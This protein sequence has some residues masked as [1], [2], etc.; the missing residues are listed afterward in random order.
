MLNPEQKQEVIQSFTNYGWCDRYTTN[1]PYPIRQVYASFKNDPE[2]I[3]TY[4]NPKQSYAWIDFEEVESHNIQKKQYQSA[5][6]MITHRLITGLWGLPMCRDPTELVIYGGFARSA[7]IAYTTCKSAIYKFMLCWRKMTG[8]RIQPD[9]AKL[10][11]GP[12]IASWFDSMVYF[13]DKINDI[14]VLV[15]YDEKPTEDQFRMTVNTI[16]EEISGMFR[17]KQNTGYSYNY[18][19]NDGGFDRN[20]CREGETSHKTG[21]YFNYAVY[22]DQD[23]HKGKHFKHTGKQIKLDITALIDSDQSDVD[24]NNV[25]L[26]FDRTKGRFRFRQ[27]K[28]LMYWGPELTMEQIVKSLMTRTFRPVVLKFKAFDSI[29]VFEKFYLVQY[30]RIKRLEDQGWKQS[31]VAP[32]FGTSQNDFD[33]MI[34]RAR[35]YFDRQSRDILKPV[36]EETGPEKPKIRYSKKCIEKMEEDEEVPVQKFVSAKKTN[37]RRKNKSKH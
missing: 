3:V 19:M 16:R 25:V 37:S 9:V 14:D 33:L 36:D 22:F 24:I 26:Y 31:T 7:L 20:C 8:C 5:W 6:V 35:A 4:M 23:K 11:C 28:K 12:I 1:G 30:Y 2:W 34:E 17:N 15:N 29:A 32:G 18:N 21:D 10:I 27:R 13:Q